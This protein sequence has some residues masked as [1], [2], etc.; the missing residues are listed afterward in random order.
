M[1]SILFVACLLV[2]LLVCDDARAQCEG[3]ICSLPGRVVVR[4]S[5]RTREVIVRR[6]RAVI[7]VSVR[8]AHRVMNT[9]K[10][11]AVR[12]FRRMCFGR[13]ND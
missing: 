8:V 6:E 7:T 12:P 9:V 10:E 4:A 13:R 5:Q 3:A 2:A 1:K 11:V